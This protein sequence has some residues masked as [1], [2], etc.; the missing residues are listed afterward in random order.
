MLKLH[1][2]ITYLA[3]FVSS[4]HTY[5]LSTFRATYEL[6][7]GPLTVGEMHRTFEL[8][9]QGAYTFV[10]TFKTTGFAALV[11]KEQVS[12]IST[13]MLDAGAFLPERYTYVRKSRKKPRNVAMRFNRGL[14]TIETTVNAELST[15]DLK[16]G[17]L[18]KLIYQAA[19][20]ADLAAGSHILEY[21]IA[22]RGKEKTY[23]PSVETGISI[24]T[25]FGQLET[26]KVVRLSKNGQ[27]KT[28]FWCAS[29][30]NFLPVRV[31]HADDDGTETV[32]SLVEYTGV[33][34]PAK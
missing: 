2:T 7:V 16:P 11:R 29:K 18:D 15:S 1:T 25:I 9:E 22:D 31:L 10:S 33:R 19:L 30:L 32:V 27:K 6:T 5:A 20:M 26:V 12:E 3:L 28:I 8:N 34:S 4:T 17:T 14:S 24:D 21:R 23:R 13:G